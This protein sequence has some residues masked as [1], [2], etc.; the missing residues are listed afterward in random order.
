MGSLLIDVIL[1]PLAVCD[2]TGEG[3]KL[4]ECLSSSVNS[5]GPAADRSAPESG[6]T[7]ITADLFAVVMQIL[8]MRAGSAVVTCLKADNWLGV[9]SVVVVLLCG[10]RC[11]SFVENTGD[12]CWVGAHEHCA[13]HIYPGTVSTFVAMVTGLS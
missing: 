1:C 5:C 3:R 9:G 13:Q 8:V 12:G 7:E 10:G 6:K 11:I 2:D 4:N